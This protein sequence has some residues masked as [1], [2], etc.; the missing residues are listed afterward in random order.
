MIKNK[1]GIELPESIEGYGKVKAYQGA[2][3]TIPTGMKA[4]IKQSYSLPNQ[5]KLV[6]TLSEAIVKSGLKSGMTISFHHHLRDGDGVMLLVVEE[7]AKQGIKDIHINASS[8]TNAHE[9]IIEYIKSGVITKISTSGLRGKLAEEISKNGILP[10]PITFRT[11]GGRARAIE[12]GDSHIDVTFVGAPTC[13]PLGNMNGHEGPC[14]FGAMGYPM[15]DVQYADVV[16]ALTDFLQPHP[17]RYISIDQTYVDYVVEVESLGDPA[18]IAS[19]ATRITSNPSELLIAQKAAK[20]LIA[21]GLIQ[22]GFSFQAGAGG[23]ALAVCR[24]IREYMEE[25]NIKGGFASGGINSYLVELLKAGLFSRLLDVQTFDGTIAKSIHEN[26]D[27]CEMSASMYAN[28]HNKSCIAHQLDIMIL[29]AT[30]IDLDFNVNSLTGSHG[31]IMGA[32]GGAPDTAAGAKL[33]VMVVPALRKRLPIVVEKVTHII[34]PNE[35]VDVLVT[36]RGICVNPNRPDVLAKLKEARVPLCDIKE[37][38]ED[39]KQ[40]TGTPKKV[41]CSDKIVGVIEYRDG[42]VLDIIRQVKS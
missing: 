13:D 19:G 15:V 8:F 40:L 11:H 6:A 2:F 4:N 33:T 28:P 42:T 5:S 34:T 7:I 29:S 9:G 3:A 31:I 18:K 22:T 23:A 32:I 39:I 26:I 17:L 35:T 14:A 27:H 21:S 41:E 16:I 37:L 30:E 1:L 36:D 12:S 10:N 24:Y 25:N 38:Y 20:V